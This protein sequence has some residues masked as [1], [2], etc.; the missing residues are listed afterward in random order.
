MSSRP[1]I[2]ALAFALLCGS[3]NMAAAAPPPPLTV[4]LGPGRSAVRVN[5]PFKV[6]LWVINTSHSNQTV[7][8]M[9]C[10][11]YDEWQTSNTNLIPK[12]WDCTKNFPVNVNLRPGDFYTNELEMSVRASFPPGKLRFRMGF[13]PIGGTTT[14]WSGNIELTVL[15]P[16]EPADL[17]QEDKAFTDE[18][19]KALQDCK[20][21]KVGMTR[22]QLL[23]VFEPGGGIYN[24][25]GR[26]FVYR[27]CEYI[28]VDVEF[29]L[30]SPDQSVFEER[31][32]DTIS[33]ISEPFLGVPPTD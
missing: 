13:T 22:P 1:I 19:F 8:V 25:M 17:P 11:W 2:L 30:S 23:E 28:E 29:K 14:F 6:A 10:S 12:L 33:K 24:A 16:G 26:R 20:K 15:P 5:A 32:T 21:I 31:M 9:N 27:R 18:V 3:R 4:Q 7:R